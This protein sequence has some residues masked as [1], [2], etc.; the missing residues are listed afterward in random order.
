MIVAVNQLASNSCVKSFKSNSSTLSIENKYQLCR[1]ECRIAEKVHNGAQR[2]RDF[3]FVTCSGYKTRPVLLVGPLCLKNM[4][5]WTRIVREVCSSHRVQALSPLWTM[6]IRIHR[7]PISYFECTIN[8]L[9]H[10]VCL[11]LHSREIMDMLGRVRQCNVLHFVS[12][13]ICC[14]QIRGCLGS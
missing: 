3:I 6:S 7:E 4:T 10:L 5:S 9:A 11:L 1:Q 8:T 12:S 2:T 14:E 13:G